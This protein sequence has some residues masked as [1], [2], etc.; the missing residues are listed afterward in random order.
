MIEE[1]KSVIFFLGFTADTE[2]LSYDLKS[3]APAPNFS[4][5]HKKTKEQQ[6]PATFLAMVM[7]QND[8]DVITSK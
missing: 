6:I 5:I 8:D 7:H 4:L 1:K 2:F 3:E